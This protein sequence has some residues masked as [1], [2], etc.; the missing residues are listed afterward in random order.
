MSAVVLVPDVLSFFPAKNLSMTPEHHL[1]RRPNDMR[2]PTVSKA[3]PHVL[4]KKFVEIEAL[5]LRADGTFNLEIRGGG[6][7]KD[8]STKFGNLEKRFHYYLGSWQKMSTD[9]KM[10]AKL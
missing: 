2:F 4:K 10:Q 5:L 8:S 9:S 6:A 7:P 3:D 1:I